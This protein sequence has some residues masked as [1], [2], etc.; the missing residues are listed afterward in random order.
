MAILHEKRLLVAAAL[1]VAAIAGGAASSVASAAVPSA[2]DGK[3][4]GCY[5][6]NAS[7]TDAKGALRIID[8][9]NSACTGAETAINWSPTGSTTGAI[10]PDLAGKDL[11]G[12]SLDNRDLTGANLSGSNLSNMRLHYVDMH[13]ANFTGANLTGLAVVGSTF[14]GAN[15]TNAHLDFDLVSRLVT[16]PYL[17][18]LDTNVDMRNANFTNAYI[19]GP[20]VDGYA[21]ETDY[22]GA[23]FNNTTIFGQIGNANVSG[24][25]FRTTHFLTNPAIGDYAGFADV[26]ASNANFSGMTLD[27]VTFVDYNMNLDH[28]NFSNTTFTNSLLRNTR[29]GTVGANFTNA[30][31]K[32]SDFGDN[33]FMTADFTGAYIKDSSFSQS[34]INDANFTGVTWINVVCPDE[35]NSDNN[36]GTCVGH[37]L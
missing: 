36:G 32:D 18:K 29:Q 23:T 24:I 4:Y 7:L 8:N 1:V 34:R 2:V 12:L 27:H 21:Y 17:N 20:D 22:R 30:V 28:T 19:A 9:A 33:R 6:N 35:S 31:I 14:Q 15:F 11:S 16:S 10:R 25:D 37:S 5:R 26:D 3:I 13:N